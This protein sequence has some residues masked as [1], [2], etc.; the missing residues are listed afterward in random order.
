MEWAYNL[1]IDIVMTM[2]K[3]QMH[4]HDDVGAKP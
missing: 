4:S 3:Q 2:G 1:G